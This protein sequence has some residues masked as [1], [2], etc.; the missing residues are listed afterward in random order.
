MTPVRD[1]DEGIPGQDV[2]V[3]GVVGGEAA[4]FT[5]GPYSLAG[6]EPIVIDGVEHVPA[7]YM[8]DNDGSLIIMAP[9]DP[10]EAASDRKRIGTVGLSIDVKRGNG[11][12]VTA[13]EDP[14]QMATARLWMAAPDLLE[15]LRALLTACEEDCGVPSDCDADDEA[16]GAGED[17]DM[18]L[19]FGMLRR[20]RAA[21]AKALPP[22]A[23]NSPEIIDRDD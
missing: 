8:R 12:R 2:P 19:T 18:A 11:W 13:D 16:V 21:I 6:T 5:P 1:G 17:G 10:S 7:Q 20:A 9:D 22:P 3:S 4:G 14:R 23:P 15:A